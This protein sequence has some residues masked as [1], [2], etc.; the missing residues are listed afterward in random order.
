MR[1]LYLSVAAVAALLCASCQKNNDVNIP[2]E[3][4]SLFAYDA[5]AKTALNEGN[6]SVAWISSDNLSVFNAAAGSTTYSDNCRF[7]ISGTPGNG[8]FIKDPAQ[9]DKNLVGD[10][11][12]YDW[13]AC[14]PWME[15]GA[16]PGATKGYTVATSFQQVGYNTTGHIAHYDIM[17]GKALAVAAGTA[18]RIALHHVGALMKF[19]VTNATGEATPITSLTLDASQGGSYIS[20]SF[21]M[22]WGADGVTPALDASQMG[23]SKSYTTTVNIVKNVGTEEAPSYVPTDVNVEAGASVDIYMVVAPFSIA[24]GKSVKISVK[25]GFGEVTIDKTMSRAVSFA[26]GTYNTAGVS[27]TKPQKSIFTETFGTAA[28]ATGNVATYG[29]SGLTCGYDPADAAS[30]VYASYNNASFQTADYTYTTKTTSGAYVRYPKKGAFIAIKN[31]KLH[32]YT[33]FT[34][35]FTKDTSDGIALKW[36]FSDESAWTT[37]ATTTDAGEISM[38]FTISNP[39]GKT[40]DIQLASTMDVTNSAWPTTD[41]WK[42]LVNE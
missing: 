12:S 15:Y 7:L 37:V 10:A 31:I 19:T 6:W 5:D 26:A 23:S 25:G 29:K 24:A 28:V 2:S 30:Y 38:P 32:G 11:A 20:G 21:T 35:C 1:K 16:K 9:T 14:Y 39:D 33:S 34:F 40:I 36:R 8:Q 18:P 41:N 13:Y 27:Y 3:P 17:A 4:V 22:N 42:L